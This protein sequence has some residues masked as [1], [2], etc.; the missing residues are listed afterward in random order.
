MP[1]TANVRPT[2]KVNAVKTN[3]I[4]SSEVKELRPVLKHEPITPSWIGRVSQLKPGTYA[5]G[6]PTIRL[7]ISA[8][9]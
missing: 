9:S 5:D 7:N 3:G 1:A 8:A 4:K 2:V 6:M